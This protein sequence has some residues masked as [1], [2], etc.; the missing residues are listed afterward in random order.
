MKRTSLVFHNVLQAK[1]RKCKA[2]E[3]DLYAR[4]L[5]N[6]VIRNELYATGPVFYQ[7]SNFN[8]DTMEGDYS[9]YVPVNVPINMPENDQ[10]HFFE[11]FEYKDGLLYRFTDFDEDIE[12][13]YEFMKAAAEELNLTLKEPFYNIYLDVYG[14]GIIDIY[15]P[16]IGGEFK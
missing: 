7:V 6:A 2:D 16:I 8:E 9:F 15:A 5:R 1:N 12:V 14:E 3:W 11:T 10:Y 13:A 4:E